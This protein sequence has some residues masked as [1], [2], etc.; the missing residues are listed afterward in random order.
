MY[1]DLTR[2]PANR[3]AVLAALSHVVAKRGFAAGSASFDG[4]AKLLADPFLDS[5]I[6]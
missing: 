6:Q 4:F 5:S 2:A 3:R 1:P